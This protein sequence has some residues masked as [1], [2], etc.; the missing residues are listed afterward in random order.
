MS[1]L[2]INWPYYPSSVYGLTCVIHMQYGMTNATRMII[3]MFDYPRSGVPGR[4][5]PTNRM[6]WIPLPNS[7]HPPMVS[8]LQP[9]RARA[10]IALSR[11]HFN[12]RKNL[13]N[14][15]KKLSAQKL[16]NELQ[17]NYK[18][19]NFIYYYMALP[20]VSRLVIRLLQLRFI[21]F[22]FFIFILYY[23]DCL[24]CMFFFFIIH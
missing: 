11:C 7:T 17:T 23:Y 2:L 14:N 10:H 24:F 18:I 19:Y 12:Q 9:A 8:R 21:F 6:K 16:C 22:F 13:S 4:C 15:K 3:I 20:I 5:V 1:S